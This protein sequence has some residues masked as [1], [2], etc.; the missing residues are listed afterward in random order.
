[1]CLYFPLFAVA[2]KKLENKMFHHLFKHSSGP[3]PKAMAVN[4]NA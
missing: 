2:T 1:M 3:E 4:G